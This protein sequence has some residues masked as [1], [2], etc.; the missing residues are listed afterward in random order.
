MLSTTQM[1]EPSY[2]KQ[3]GFVVN[4]EK[5][6]WEPSQKQEWLG[7]NINL[8]AGEFSVPTQKIEKLKEN[9][10]MA[11]HAKIRPSWPV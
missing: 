6:V 11:M 7:F 2:L 1:G 5:S 4:I 8:A 10:A 3:A 9:L